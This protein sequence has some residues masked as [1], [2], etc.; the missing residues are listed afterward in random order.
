MGIDFL[1][2]YGLLFFIIFVFF[3][4]YKPIICLLMFGVFALFYVISSIL[5]LNK[6]NKN[7]IEIFGEIV[8]YESDDE[9][10]KTPIIE[11]QT[12]EGKNFTGKPILFTSSN[13]DN[14]QPY[15]KDSNKTTK[16]IYNPE[17]P[18]EFIVKNNSKTFGL[19]LFTI[20]GFVST[21]ISVTCLLGFNDIF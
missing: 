14:F 9:G 17:E 12:L 16:I 6:L 10:Y 8:S 18:E 3:A 20:L 19:I 15:K 2:K 21:A 7:G 4:F 1:K 5:F 11:F 13:L